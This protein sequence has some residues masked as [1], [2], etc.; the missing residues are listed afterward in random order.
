[1]PNTARQ[2]LAELRQCID[3]E[4]VPELKPKAG[5]PYRFKASLGQ[6]KLGEQDTRQPLKLEGHRGGVYNARKPASASACTRQAR[7]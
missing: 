5:D 6:Q 2:V 1:M 3:V 4:G 7:I